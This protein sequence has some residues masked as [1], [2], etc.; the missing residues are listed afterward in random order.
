MAIHP[1]SIVD[2]CAEIDAG[3][4]VGPFC[5]IEAH[6]R[7]SAGCRLYQNVYLT[8]WTQIGEDCELHPGVIVGHKPQD[9]KYGGERSYCRVGRRTILREN[10]TIHRGTTPESYT[11]VGEEC[12]FLANSHVGH[13]AVV[14][15]RVT[16][17]N[18]ALL[19][20]HVVVGD[21]AT[22][23]GGAGVH[24]FVRIGQLAMVAG[25]A[26]VL[27]DIVPFALTDSAGRIA[28]I[29]RV[30]LRRAGFT[31]DEV[32]RIREAYRTLFSRGLPFREAVN[33]LSDESASDNIDVLVEFLRQESKRGHA[34]RSR[35]SP[36][37]GDCT[38]RP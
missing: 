2:P 10:V 31:A 35:G 23:G 34:G 32:R 30:G 26:T 24:Q 9:T 19:G 4:E 13:N 16:L 36:S 15:D 3:V 22:L 5:V 6:V 12:F 38:H 7:V 14:G 25:N 27:M 17:I 1:T 37:Q 21:G 29:N 28:G 18:N 20:G 11:L 8:G 33:R